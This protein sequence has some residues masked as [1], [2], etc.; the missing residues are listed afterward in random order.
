MKQIRTAIALIILG[1]AP[2]NAQ[3]RQNSLPL[4]F[5]GNPGLANSGIRFIVETPELRAGF[6]S[7]SVVFQ[8]PG[9]QAQLRFVNASRKTRIEPLEPSGAK[10]NFMIG[11]DAAKWST[12]V[13]TYRK[14]VYRDLYPGIDMNFGGNTRR[15]KSEFIVGPGADANQI[16]L[17]YS[18]VDDVR[19]D[20]NGEL[21]V[22]TNGGQLRESAPLIFQDTLHGRAQVDGHY[23]MLPDRTVGF[24]IGAYDHSMP[25]VIDPTISYSTYLGGTGLGSVTGVAVDASGNAYVTGWTEALNFPIVGAAQVASGGGVDAFIVKLNAAGNAIVYATYIGGTGDDRAA[26]IAV[27]AAGEAYVTG[28]TASSNF[29]KVSS[30]RSTLGGGRDAFVV[31]LNA[32]GNTL[33][34]ST[35]LGGTSNDWGNAIALD[36]SGNVFVA[37]DTLSTDFPTSTPAQAANGGLQDAFVTKLSASGALVFSTYL[38]GA[39]NEHAGGIAVGAGGVVY[40]AGG[41]FSTNFPVVSA[42]QGTNGGGEDA[43]V[44]KIA[45]AGNSFVYSTYLGG[46]GGT[47]ASPEQANGIAVDASGN[48]YVAGATNSSNFPVKTGAFQGTFGGIQDAFLTKINATGSALAYST[49]LGGSSFDWANGVAVDASGN[50]YVAGYTSSYDWPVSSAVQAVFRGMYD[51]FVTEVNA[52][53]SGLIFSTYFGGTGSDQANAIALDPNNSIFIGGQT[54]S[55]DMPVANAVQYSKTGN[56]VG[57]VARLGVAAPLLQLAMTHPIDV[58]QGQSVTLTLSVSNAAGAP[59]TIGTVTVIDTLPSGFSLTSMSGAGWTCAGNSCSR[60]DSLNSGSAFPP[61]AVVAQV[62]ASAASPQ[63][64]LASASGGGGLMVQSSDSVA[65]LPGN[66]TLSLNPASASMGIAGGSYAVTITAAIG[67]NWTATSNAPWLAITSP[68]S[69]SG[70]GTVY[71]S[72]ASTLPGAARVGT[73]TIGSMPLTVSQSAVAATANFIGKFVTSYD[74]GNSALYENNGNVGIYTA[75]PIIS[76]DVRSGGLAQMGVAGKTDYLTVFASDAFGPALYWNPAMD[77]RFGRGGASLYNP[78]GFME[79][80]RIQSSTGNVGIGTQS[81]GAKVDVAGDVNFAGRIQYQGSPLLQLPGGIQDFNVSLGPGA[82]PR[83]A[84][85]S[86]TAIG[87]LSLQRDTAGANNTAIG[88]NALFNNTAG[89]TNTGAGAGALLNGPAS[90]GTAIGNTALMNDTGVNN[91]GIGMNAAN[92]VAGTGNTNVHI[93]NAGIVSDSSV[94]RIGTLGS[95]S[96]FFAAGV[97]GVT[98]GKGDGIPLVI[99]SNG[100]LGTISSSRRFK[101]DI[102]DMRGASLNL[103]NLRPVTYRYKQPFG[104]GSKPIQYGLIAE[105]VA[106]LFPDLVAHS[107][108]G[109]IETV[110]YQVL[111]SILLDDVQRQHAEIAGLRREIDE[112]DQISQNLAARLAKL[113]AALTLPAKKVFSIQ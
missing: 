3:N 37:G 2:G 23:R 21:I 44:T 10:A 67:C 34:F 98:T 109:R 107:A 94:V 99:D 40:V 47:V 43:F 90:G 101:E 93:G 82:F 74:V 49:Y 13:A 19:I 6:R 56:S 14:I 42:L 12:G 46:T 62:S 1:I 38:G 31:K 88:A 64:N 83:V 112:E 53:G 72:V 11:A 16:R 57:W 75:Q 68:T 71:Y 84:I 60:N 85:G 66:C 89:G 51:G 54:A 27:D 111:S 105:E 15:V 95:Q 61:I 52:A 69:G 33:L 30:L 41:T 91:I 92:S 5:F 81:P 26:A 18:G 22:S 24:E 79:L 17:E 70:S 20:S 102:R 96:A 39:Q 100:Q 36:P 50:A 29:P 55:L 86:N 77:L 80:M 48:V 45:A 65:I 73:L 97:R 87:G 32:A 63:I 4:F 59:A 8:L 58:A 28:S 35:L 7:D 76:M 9:M 110:K 113:E 106:A 103:L 78:Y 108:D 25:L 104:D